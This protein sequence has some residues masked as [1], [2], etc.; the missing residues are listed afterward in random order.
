MR[1][2]DDIRENSSPVRGTSGRSHATVSRTGEARAERERSARRATRSTRKKRRSVGADVLSFPLSVGNINAK[3]NLTPHGRGTTVRRVQEQRTEE[4]IPIRPA[5]Y[6]QKKVGI[7]DRVHI[8]RRWGTGLGIDVWKIVIV[9]LLILAVAAVAIFGPLR[10]YYVAWRDAG[11]LQVE[12]EVL[13][14]INE[15]LTSDVERLN[16]LEGIEDEARRRGYV[17]PDEEALVVEGIE[18]KDPVE[19]E[20]LKR[21]LDEYD[22]SLPWY[23]HTLDGVLGYSPKQK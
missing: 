14:T 21:A 23:I 19:Q 12:Y 16:T 22:Q 13:S 8:A 6:T 10:D 2:T 18:E 3:R 9:A 17:Y 20:E 4:G 5:V 11:V 7:R 1:T 15:D